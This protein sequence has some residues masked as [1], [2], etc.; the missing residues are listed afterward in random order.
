MP[1][2][3]ERHFKLNPSQKGRRKQA[4]KA[5]AGR[6]RARRW[7]AW[8]SGPAKVLTE[9]NLP[10]LLIK[11]Q[12]RWDDFLAHAGPHYCDPGPGFD[13]EI[14][15]LPEEHARKLWLFLET[16]LSEADKAWA[17]LYKL[18]RERFGRAKGA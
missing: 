14:D 7:K 18:L 1:R 2:R 9:I 4:H 12:W 5:A 15:D 16:H 13:W 3:I 6:E 8:L 17:G 11:D 10:R